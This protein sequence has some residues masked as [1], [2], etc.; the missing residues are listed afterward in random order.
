MDSVNVN[1]VKVHSNWT[2]S[3]A[4]SKVDLP[5]LRDTKFPITVQT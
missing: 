4:E 3:A 1:W 5:F 2:K